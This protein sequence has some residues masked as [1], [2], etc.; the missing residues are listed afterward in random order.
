MRNHLIVQNKLMYDF[1]LIQFRFYVCKKKMMTKK[2][3]CE[4]ATLRTMRNMCSAV[5]GIYYYYL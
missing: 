5:C 2:K 1:K 3:K 4:R